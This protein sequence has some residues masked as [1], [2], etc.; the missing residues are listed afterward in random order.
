MFGTLFD[1]IENIA[2][3]NLPSFDELRS[4]HALKWCFSESELQIVLE[5]PSEKTVNARGVTRLSRIDAEDIYVDGS[6][7]NYITAGV[8]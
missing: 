7:Q 3:Y 1:T 6:M 4:F 2:L 8:V 5:N